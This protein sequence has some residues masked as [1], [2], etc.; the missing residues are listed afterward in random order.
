VCFLS[1]AFFPREAAGAGDSAK[2]FMSATF[3]LS[4]T[5][6][7]HNMERSGAVV[8]N[9]AREERP[10]IKGRPR[11][12]SAREKSGR[13]RLT[14]KGRFKLRSAT[15]VFEFLDRDGLNYK[16][17]YIASSGNAEKDLALYNALRKE[18]NA[19]FGKTHDERFSAKTCTWFEDRHTT[20]T[21]S[22]NT[23]ASPGAH[24]IRLIYA[25]HLNYR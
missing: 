14:M 19:R 25:R 6:T 4:S 3:G 21:L 8:S 10:T 18:F 2:A 7:R 17:A 16:A 12:R 11:P 20:I 13:E 22:C 23:G 5:S 15:F 24:S 9:V 1:S